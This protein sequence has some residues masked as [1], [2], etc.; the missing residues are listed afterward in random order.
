MRSRNFNPR[1]PLE[2]ISLDDITS[3]EL[4]ESNQKINFNHYLIDSRKA[5]GK[6]L[7]MRNQ[8]NATSLDKLISLINPEVK[9]NLYQDI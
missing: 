7:I 3:V 4:R 1:K 5:N 9:N 6:I 2:C 8:I